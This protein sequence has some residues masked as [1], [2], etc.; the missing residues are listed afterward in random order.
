MERVKAILAKRPGE[1][2]LSE[3]V[4]SRRMDW[5]TI[6]PRAPH[7]GALW[8][9]AVKSMKHHLRRVI[10]QQVLS[11][12]ELNTILVQVEGILNSRPLTAASEDPND[13][14][15]ITPAHFLTGGSILEPPE[16]RKEIDKS[17]TLS[18]RLHLLNRLKQDF[19]KSWRRDYLSTLQVRRKWTQDGL[20]FKQGDL[21][22]LAEDNQGPMQWKLGRILEVFAGNDDLV[23]VVK[24]KTSSGELIR[25]IVKLRKLPVDVPMQLDPPGSAAQQ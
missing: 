1:N 11:F 23:R 18:Q 25:P 13:L 24:V 10:G 19:W 16:V 14:R 4:S 20:Q 8:E 3:D 5:V 9:A 22:L 12:E 15:T 6:P 7:F 2:S 17:S 21:V